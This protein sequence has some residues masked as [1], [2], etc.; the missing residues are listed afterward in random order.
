MNKT[1][2]CVIAF[3]AIGVG[4]VEPSVKADPDPVRKQVEACGAGFGAAVST[5]LLAEYD[6]KKSELSGKADAGI[7]ASTETSSAFLPLLPESD[8]L[9]GYKTYTT[10]L[11]DKI[12]YPSGK[13]P[14]ADP[15]IVED[16]A[17]VKKN[18]SWRLMFV[19]VKTLG[20]LELRA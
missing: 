16:T 14:P 15:V 18:F 10:C 6:I 3:S 5:K 4:C 2:L 13:E 17:E 11:K 9:D 7:E 19:A 8:R 20:T 1:V 12:N